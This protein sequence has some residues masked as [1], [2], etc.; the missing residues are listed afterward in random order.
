MFDVRSV[1]HIISRGRLRLI[2]NWLPLRSVS[3]SVLLRWA[4]LDISVYRW[5]L[6]MLSRWVFLLLLD[7]WKRTL[8][9]L[10]DTWPCHWIPLRSF[11]YHIISVFLDII[12]SGTLDPID[13]RILCFLSATSCLL[14]I[15]VCWLLS[16]RVNIVFF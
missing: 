9:F 10:F 7:L 3:F 1:I 15:V 11:T 12:L 8:I 14:V 13:N 16:W 2:I 4:L 6:R 5:L